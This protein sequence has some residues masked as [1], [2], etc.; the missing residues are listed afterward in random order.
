MEKSE[1]TDPPNEM[2]NTKRGVDTLEV[3]SFVIII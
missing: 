1:K 3:Y 2:L